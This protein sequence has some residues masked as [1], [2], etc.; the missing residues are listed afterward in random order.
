MGASKSCRRGRWSALALLTALLLGSAATA[1]AQADSTN[2]NPVVTA[3][4]GNDAARAASS[5]SLKITQ[6]D[7]EE[8]IGKLAIALPHTS[9]FTVN[10]DVPGTDGAQI[11]TIHVL[12]YTNP[13]PGTL[14]IDGTLNDDN[15]RPG[16]HVPATRQCILANLDVAGQPVRAQ[17]EINEIGGTYSI[18]GDLTSTWADPNVGAIDARLAELSTTLVAKVGAHAVITNPATA[19]SWPLTYRLTSAQVPGR[20][21]G[22]RV[23]V[24]DPGCSVPLTTTEYSPGKPGLQSPANGAAYLS[25]TPIRFA[26]GAS[27]DRNGDTVTYELLVDGAPVLPLDPTGRTADVALAPGTH[28]W[29]VR[30]DD[31]HGLRSE[32][33]IWNVTTIDASTALRFESTTN[34]DVLHIDPARH[35]FVYQVAGSG[36]YGAVAQSANGPTGYLAF[37]SGFTLAIAFDDTTRS[38][39]GTFSGANQTRPFLDPPGA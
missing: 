24:C 11:G 36:Q 31:G 6:A 28:T 15:S 16:C 10:T 3:S 29:L 35:A 38:A 39:V 20:S 9:A 17:L 30:A 14:T 21:V 4:L 12:L 27:S 26:W 37:N 33:P 25:T 2:F 5:F 23:P 18:E 32:S 1:P 34:G 19:G 8:Q 22:G 7:G 13:R